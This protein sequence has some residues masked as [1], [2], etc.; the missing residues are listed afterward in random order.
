M[1]RL[2]SLVGL[3]VVLLC[4]WGL[5]EDRRRVPWRV[6]GWGL[7]LQFGFGLLVLE[8]PL[9]GVFFRGSEAA[10]KV[11]TDATL[12]G[13][14]FMFGT[15]AN[16]YK[17]NAL[18]A[19]QV[20][21]LI[22][23]VSSLAAILYHLRIIQAVVHGMTWIMRHTLKTS[24][25]ETFAAAVQVFFGIEAVPTLRGYLRTM[26]RSE[27]FV[28]MVTFMATIAGSVLVVYATFGA[29]P[30]HLLTA[31]LISA[32]AA[33]MIA[34]LMV[35][36]TEEPETRGRV[37]IQVPVESHNIVDAATRGAA[38]GLTLAL[39]I[40]AMIIA[41]VGLVFLVNLAFQSVTGYTFTA[42]MGY[43]FRPVAL[44]LGVPWSDAAA[45]G[46]L[47]GIKTVMNEFLGYARMKEMVAA[48]TLSPRGVTI[49]TYALCGF[50][51]PGSLGI[52]VA[53]LT[54]L[55][56]ERREVIVGLGVKSFIAGILTGLATACVAGVLVA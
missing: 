28:V 7:A 38:E 53:G 48:G 56:P 42:L 37:Q 30:G 22:I 10:V 35:P 40:G 11:L 2:V 8:T 18:M 6:I 39:N 3:G 14:S 20:L 29:Q 5:S 17:T 12:A 4:A 21:P 16:D 43:V 13:A 23:F 36:E 41:F 9:A 32:P 34:K 1:L 52:L 31:S 24:G 26:T 55:A 15:L 25:A 54:G 27:L 45:V 47:L 33:L 44:L 19:F 51:N 49:A 50:A 46:E